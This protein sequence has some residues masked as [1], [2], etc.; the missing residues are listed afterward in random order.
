[1]REPHR[2]ASAVFAL[3]LRYVV[4][5][6][7]TRDDL[8][9]GGAGLFSA[10]IQSVR[11]KC[12]GCRVEVLV[13]DFKGSVQS[14]ETVIDALPD[15]LSHNIES[16]PSLYHMVRPQADYGR[17][18]ELL[19]R[20][21]GHGAITKS[22]IML[23]LGESISE[24]R[25]VMHDLYRAG[26]SILTLGQYLQPD[27]DCLTVQ[28]YYHPDEFALLRNEALSMGFHSV[29]AGPLVRSSYRAGKYCGND[30]DTDEDATGTNPLQ[31][32]D[33]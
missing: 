2:V 25:S 1:M 29:V 30:E 22:G 8:S 14:L 23:G 24:V 26:C 6:S 32:N 20:A 3:N 28:R 17:S 5:T 27:R 31:P 13:P 33:S 4:I 10:T 19:R 21:R 15:V 18:L 7:V 16:V 11:K 12:P 9:D